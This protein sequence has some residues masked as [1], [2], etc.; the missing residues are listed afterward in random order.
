LPNL[1][2]LFSQCTEPLRTSQH[3]GGV[4]GQANQGG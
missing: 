1:T 3:D 2:P 4:R